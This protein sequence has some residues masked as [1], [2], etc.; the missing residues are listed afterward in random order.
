M[1]LTKLSAKTYRVKIV[2][3]S[4]PDFIEMRDWLTENIGDEN[5]T[6]KW[7]RDGIT[8]DYFYFHRDE[9]IVAFKL[10]WI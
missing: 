10:M 5:W 8:I 4:G 1:R 7:T 9:D 3:L 6:H 2:D